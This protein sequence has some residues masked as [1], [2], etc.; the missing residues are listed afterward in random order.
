VLHLRNVPSGAV[1][2]LLDVAGRVLMEQRASTERGELPVAAHAPGIYLVSV[3]H[4]G[5]VVTHRVV[6]ER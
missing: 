5:V 3:Q 1:V 2:R 4:D 6:V